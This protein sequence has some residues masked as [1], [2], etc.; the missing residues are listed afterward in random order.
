MAACLQHQIQLCA[1]AEVKGVWAVHHAD[2]QTDTGMQLD[3]QGGPHHS[4]MLM[5]HPSSA[6]TKVLET[7][8]A[9]NQLTDAGAFVTD[10]PTICAG[11]ILKHTL[12]VQASFADSLL[13]CLIKSN[14]TL[15]VSSKGLYLT[16]V[17][18]SL[19]SQ[20]KAA[21][22]QHHTYLLPVETIACSTAGAYSYQALSTG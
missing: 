21:R 11:N 6:E 4:L 1:V 13:L 20:D 12:I 8:D 14:C 5:S 15:D 18:C 7:G 2:A 19:T 9:M 17:G 3:V 16:H 22:V 10:A